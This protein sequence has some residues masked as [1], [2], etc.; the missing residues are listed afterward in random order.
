MRLTPVLEQGL[1]LLKEN[2]IMY[3]RK[4]L[5]WPYNYVSAKHKESDAQV[6]WRECINA[7]TVNRLVI[8]GYAE[9]ENKK[10]V[11][12]YVN[13]VESAIKFLEAEGYKIT[14]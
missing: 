9:F 13:K 2:K 8:M 4:D 1:E 11:V 7:Q 10:E 3:R 6:P 5:G 14:R 12:K